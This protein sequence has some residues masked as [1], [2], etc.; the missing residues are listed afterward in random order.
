M[1][2]RHARF[3]FVYSP[4]P[5][6]AISC[7]VVIDNVCFKRNKNSKTLGENGLIEVS[8]VA[9]KVQRNSAKQRKEEKQE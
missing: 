9:V 2:Q 5:P 6:S 8:M 4:P 3:D 1:L 7:V